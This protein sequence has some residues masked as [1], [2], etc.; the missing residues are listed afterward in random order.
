MYGF[1][2]DTGLL[3]SV[4]PTRITTPIDVKD[5]GITQETIHSTVESINAARDEKIPQMAQNIQ[6]EK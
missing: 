4:L 3:N 1:N 2:Q 6:I 5:T